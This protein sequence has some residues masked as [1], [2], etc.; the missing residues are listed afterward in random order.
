[1]TLNM[2]PFHVWESACSCQPADGSHSKLQ[3]AVTTKTAP[4][5]CDSRTDCLP[6]APTSSGMHLRLP[7][8][9]CLQIAPMA[10]G[11]IDIQYAQVQC[12][13][14][15][16]MTVLVDQ[17]RGAGGWIRLQISVSLPTPADPA[18]QTAQRLD[19]R[20]AFKWSHSSLSRTFENV[21]TT[22]VL[23]AGTC[24][25][26]WVGPTPAEL[27]VQWQLL[28]FTH[29]AG[30]RLYADSSLIGTPCRQEFSHP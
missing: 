7:G 17:N 13:P 15:S 6:I 30:S 27:P 22:H 5:L 26:D 20:G 12:T 19:G 29:A 3:M 8:P 1:M 9:A 18:L 25:Q 24:Q 2:H 4:D 11:L 16:P 28:S 14:P 21:V 23:M 10:G